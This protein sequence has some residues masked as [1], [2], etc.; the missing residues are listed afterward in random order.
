MAVPL[1]RARNNSILPLAQLVA[2]CTAGVRE[3]NVYV[4]MYVAMI[5]TGFTSYKFDL[6]VGTRLFY[7]GKRKRTVPDR[8][9]HSS[10][11]KPIQI[12]E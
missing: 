12:N 4:H 2:S 5:Q 9:C 7:S 3:F 10:N 8:I 11:I 6:A 1:P